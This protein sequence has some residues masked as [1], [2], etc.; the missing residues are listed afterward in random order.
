MRKYV[1]IASFIVLTLFVVIFL[2]NF[3]NA[4]KLLYGLFGYKDIKYK[5]NYKED[6]TK[7]P[8]SEI[9]VL[10]IYQLNENQKNKIITNINLL[11]LPKFEE[12][13]LSDYTPEGAS[14]YKSW[15]PT[16]IKDKTDS[17]FFN[18][19]FGTT[20]S[21]NIVPEIR[22]NGYKYAFEQGNYYSYYSSY[23]TGTNFFILNTKSCQ[24]FH[25]R[26]RR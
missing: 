13:F 10:Y 12:G 1:L 8:S 6:Y 24:L 17:I 14:N 25:V 11:K 20:L 2:S 21:I 18:S 3:T 23:L 22:I 4:N 7:Y 5:I 16:P 15:T 19:S 26:H 9:L